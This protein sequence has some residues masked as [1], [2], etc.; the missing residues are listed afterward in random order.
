M[1]REPV[2]LLGMHRSGTSLIARLLGRAGLFMGND[3][4]RN[5]E[6]F[7]FQDLNNWMLRSAG[8]TWDRPENFNFI[9]PTLKSEMLRVIDLQFMSFCRRKKYLGISKALRYRDLRELDF[10]WGW[11]DPRNTFTIDVW[12]D[13]FSRMKLIHVYRNPIDVARSLANREKYEQRKTASGTRRTVKNRLKEYAL[14][15]TVLYQYSCRVEDVHE[16]IMLWEMYTKRALS[17]GKTGDGKVLHLKFEEVL[18]SP[19]DQIRSLLRFTGLDPAESRIDELVGDIHPGRG[20][21]FINDK[22]AREIHEEVKNREL[23]R[24]LG[25][26]ELPSVP[27]SVWSETDESS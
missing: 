20:W 5:N 23:V 12:K 25:Y 16:G 19:H 3:R 18:H 26:H 13:V 2:I 10:P 6:S 8:A 27:K 11:K 4:D 9:N 24:R 21:A 17:L 7:F 22:K 1:K 14:A 15:G